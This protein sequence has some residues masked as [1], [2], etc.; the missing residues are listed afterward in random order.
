MEKMWS[1]DCLVVKFLGKLISVNIIRDI[2][3]SYLVPKNPRPL[4]VG[5]S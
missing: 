3:E 4:G 2:K 5:V 1:M